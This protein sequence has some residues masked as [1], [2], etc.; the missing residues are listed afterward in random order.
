MIP[1]GCIRRTVPRK[2]KLKE[3]IPKSMVGTDTPAS[4]RPG[5]VATLVGTGVGII[6]GVA[7]GVGEMTPVGEGAG[8]MTPVGEGAGTKTVG[9]GMGVDVGVAEGV[10]TK[11]GPS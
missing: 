6:V 10:E 5:S 11:E 1:L 4:G 8:E 7:A 9:V 3:A 2:I